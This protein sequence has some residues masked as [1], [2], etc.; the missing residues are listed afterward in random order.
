MTRYPILEVCARIKSHAV[1]QKMLREYCRSFDDWQGVLE[2]AEHEGMAPLLRKHLLEAEINIPATVKR[3]LSILYKR[4]QH[5]AQVRLK[6]I[7]DL[8]QLFNDN[9]IQSILIKGSSLCTSLYVDPALRPMRDI[10]ILVNADNIEQA[11]DLL[12]DAGFVESN[13]YNPQTHYHLPSLLQTVDGVDIC[14][15]LH[16]GL[17]PDCTP[18]Y[19]EVIFEE[20]VT[21]ARVVQIGQTAAL[22]FSHEEMLHYLYQHA[23][24]PPLTYE[25]YKLINAA[26]IISYVEK[27][28]D[29]I[30]WRIIED[31]FPG[32]SKALPL[33]HHISPWNFDIIPEAFLSAADKRRTFIPNPYKGW[34][35]KHLSELKQNASR[36]QI[37]KETFLPSRW[38]M[39]I[40]Y[41]KTGATGYI[42]SLFSEHLKQLHLF[43]GLYQA[44]GNF[45]FN[46]AARLRLLCVSILRKPFGISQKIPPK[47]N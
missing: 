39:T 34:P 6:V 45:N 17:Y 4:H 35:R 36:L 9:D 19:P 27:Y 13:S 24:R 38:W 14:I 3:S 41:G 26:D 10:D 43:A 5:K 32:F 37:I 21:T 7:E 2:R 31:R 33:M 42:C 47:K 11:Q 44:S 23:F 25:P 28:F 15:E 40:Y 12:I 16:R 18:H 20:L 1:Q 30:N 46:A 22:A 8:L 29:E